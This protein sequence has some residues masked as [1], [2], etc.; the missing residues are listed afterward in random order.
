MGMLQ[1]E[2]W[3]QL[4]QS[5]GQCKLYAPLGAT[6]MPT[7]PNARLGAFVGSAHS[8]DPH[9][10]DNLVWAI[11]KQTSAPL[12]P[13]RC[14]TPAVHPALLIEAAQTPAIQGQATVFSSWELQMAALVV[15]SPL[16]SPAAPS[17]GC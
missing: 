16:L 2:A 12:A 11:P 8:L 13:A 5:R 10:L 15:N 3:R 17:G 6:S 1:K 9:L 7:T 14:N 4:G